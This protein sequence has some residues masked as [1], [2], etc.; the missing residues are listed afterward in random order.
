ME[1][2]RDKVLETVRDPEVLQRGALDDSVASRFYAEVEE[3]GKYVFVVYREVSIQDGFI[4]TAYLEDARSARKEVVW[5]R[6]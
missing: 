3:R 6:P 2:H 1:P 5:I 4:I